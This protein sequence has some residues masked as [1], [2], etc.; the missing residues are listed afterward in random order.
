MVSGQFFLR[1]IP[2]C[3]DAAGVGAG[4][5]D[6]V[7]VAGEPEICNFQNSSIAFNLQTKNTHVS[8]GCQL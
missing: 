2:E 1:K 7:H 8:S 3:D 5:V 6:L 4:G